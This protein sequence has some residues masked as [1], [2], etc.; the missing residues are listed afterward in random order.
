EKWRATGHHLGVIMRG[1]SYIN[2][3]GIIIGNVHRGAES[4]SELCKFP[5]TAQV[6]VFGTI[7]EEGST[8]S[9]YSGALFPTTCISDEIRLLDDTWYKAY[10]FV[11][12]AD[13]VS[14]SIDET[15]SSGTIIRTI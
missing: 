9:E 1:P 13:Y 3:R 4:S 10:V 12:D 15:T 5:G 2:G 8:A 11:D 14:Y 7:P 6:E